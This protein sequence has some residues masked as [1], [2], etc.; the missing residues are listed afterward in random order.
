[1]RWAGNVACM[2]E[3]RTTHRFFVGKPE[4]KRPLGEPMDKQNGDTEVKVKETG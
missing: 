4:E 1:M 3:K 2:E